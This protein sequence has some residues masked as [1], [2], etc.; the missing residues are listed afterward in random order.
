MIIA[1]TTGKIFLSAANIWRQL[2][3]FSGTFCIDFELEWEYAP[4][5]V[6]YNSADV[7]LIIITGNMSQGPE[8]GKY[9]PGWKSNSTA[10]DLWFWVLQGRHYL[11]WW[12][13]IF[14]LKLSIVFTSSI[15]FIYWWIAVCFIAFTTQINSWYTRVHCSRGLVKKGI[16]WKGKKGTL[17]HS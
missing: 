6:D 14:S 5:C 11:Q 1:S 3:P 15:Y 4:L 2:L 7:S 16:W 13:Y 8:T 9:T 17:L 12:L 10:Q